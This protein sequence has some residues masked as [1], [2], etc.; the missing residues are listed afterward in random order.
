MIGEQDI[1]GDRL[2]RPH[3]KRRKA[4]DVISE[5]ASLWVGDLVVH[6]DHGIGRFAGLHHDHGAGRAARLP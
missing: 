2:V 1:L 5:A 6:A 4:A 3:R